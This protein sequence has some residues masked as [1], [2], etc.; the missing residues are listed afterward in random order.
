MDIIDKS[1]LSGKNK[2]WCFQY[3]ILPRIT[4]PLLMYEVPLTKVEILERM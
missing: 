2:A 4:W 1:G 3:G